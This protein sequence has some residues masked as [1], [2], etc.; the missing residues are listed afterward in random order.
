MGGDNAPHAIVAGAVRAAAELGVPVTL[1][2]R[3]EV[4]EAALDA[5]GAERE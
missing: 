1:V 5:A 3:R 2:G 4:I